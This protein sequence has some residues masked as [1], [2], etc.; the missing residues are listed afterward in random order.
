MTRLRAALAAVVLALGLLLADGSPAAPRGFT[1]PPGPVALS[2]DLHDG[3][4]YQDAGTYYL[5]GTEY[6]CGFQWYVA[7]SFCGFGV[8]TAPSLAGPWSTPQLLFPPSE[9]DP[10][11]GK[12]F[13][14]ECAGTNGHGCFNPRMLRRPDGVWLL[15]FN[16]PDARVST[17][18]SAYFVMGC[19]SPA[20]PCGAGAGAPHGSTHK[21]TLHSP[22]CAGNNGDFAIGMDTSGAVLVC[23]YG[24]TL[25]EERLDGWW[26]NGSSQGSNALADLVDVEG[27]GVWQDQA[28]GTWLMTY[29]EKCGYCTGTP[30]GYASAPSLMG[31][32]SAP[33]NTGWSA[34]LGGRRDIS[35][36]CGGQART[37]SVLDGQPWQ[38][39]DLWIGQ[40]NEAPAGVLYSPLTYQPTTGTPGD[41]A[42]WV[43]PVSYPCT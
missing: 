8:S 32:W 26:A 6:N 5:V 40:R 11:T 36:G 41:G 24:G 12:S 17:T 34:P 28:T 4:V 29:A 43:P 20:G 3:M 2:V 18:T 27:V 19:N 35:L 38:G 22:G 15:W 30:S 21:P 7:S 16:M 31:P 42:V 14:S 1:A 23:S 9:I 13:A 37:V 33:V 10:Y 39:T 25:A